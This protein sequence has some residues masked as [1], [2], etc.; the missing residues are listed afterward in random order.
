[1]TI[2]E[3]REL[4]AYNRW[5]N[6]LVFAAAA[7]LSAEQLRR[8]I[9]SSFPS[10]AASLAHIVSTEWVWL[11][12][13]RGESPTGVPAWVST[14][15]LAELRQRLSGIEAGSETYLAGLGDDDLERPISYRTLAGQP[16]AD[17]LSHVVRHVVN[18]STYH[19]G[20]ASTQFRQLGLVPPGTDFIAYVW[21]VKAG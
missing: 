17:S 19:R 11:Q 18:H 2:D 3:A 6:G 21:H 7:G 5:A 15:D 9:A 8:E 10:V 1:M 4:L 20:Q 12:R 16:H 14:A 13:W